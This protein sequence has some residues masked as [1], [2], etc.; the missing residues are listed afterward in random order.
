[1]SSLFIILGVA[2]LVAFV[3]FLP[4]KGPTQEEL[5]QDIEKLHG[6]IRNLEKAKEKK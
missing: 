6:T 2:M 5:E 4:S 1:M 3:A